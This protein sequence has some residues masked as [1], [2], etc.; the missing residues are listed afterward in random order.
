M[1]LSRGKCHLENASYVHD[2]TSKAMKTI[3]RKWFLQ[4]LPV[5]SVKYTN[6]GKSTE[7]FRSFDSGVIRLFGPAH[8][9][10]QVESK[11]KILA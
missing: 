7:Y 6:K 1:K 2:F 11:L 3:C 8:I 4:Q 9:T 5:G 10:S